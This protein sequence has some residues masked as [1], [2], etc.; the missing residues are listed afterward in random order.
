MNPRRIALVILAAVAAVQIGVPEAVAQ[1]GERRTVWDD[2]RGGFSA[3]GP[4]AKWF[5]FS[6]GPYV[7]DDGVTTTSDQGLRVVP[8]GKNPATG[9]PAF[10]RT[11]GQED[12]NGLGLPG[13]LDHVK[14]LAYMNHTAASGF[15]GFD[16]LPGQELACEAVVGGRTFGTRGHPFG[17]S[18]SG[19]EDDP[20]LATVAMNTIDFE[21]YMVFD[22]FL[23]NEGLYAVYERLPFGRTETNRY[24]SFTYVVPLGRRDPGD[25]HA[26]A[27]AYDRAAGRVRWLVDGREAF[28]VDRPG[29]RIDQRFLTLDHGGVEEDVS[30]RQMNCGM[31]MFTLLDAYRPTNTGLVRLSSQPSFY[32]NPQQGEPAPATFVDEQSRPGSRIF[33]QGAEL[34]V[35]RYGVSVRRVGR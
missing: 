1:S 24:A 6:A 16:A 13:G 23:T 8:T 21:T 7:G 32:F 29:R 9:R 22:F 17:A 4:D 11:L 18:V 26:L 10:V 25:M 28:R 34:R 20:R 2:F 27:I 12:D 5:Y 33:G 3:T 15:P 31:G 19:P 35:R 14:W 30:L